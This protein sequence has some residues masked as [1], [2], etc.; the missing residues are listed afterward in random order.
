MS[1]SR[2]MDKQNTAWNAYNG[3]LSR[4]FQKWNSD[5]FYNMGELENVAL[6]E[7]SDTKGQMLYDST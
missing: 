6:S 5:A 4:L 7:M 1:I 3:M 2:W